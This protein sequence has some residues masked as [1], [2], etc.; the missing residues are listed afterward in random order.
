MTTASRI[1][2]AVVLVAVVAAL[3]SAGGAQG[4]RPDVDWT[5]GIVDGRAYVSWAMYWGDEEWGVAYIV[6]SQDRDGHTY[7]YD[8][9][10]FWPPVDVGDWAGSRVLPPGT[11]DVEIQVRAGNCGSCAQFFQTRTITA[12]PLPPDVP[13]P[14]DDG[15]GD[16]PPLDSDG[17]GVPDRTDTCI[18]VPNPDQADTDADGLG[19]PCDQSPLPPIRVERYSRAPTPPR[20]GTAFSMGLYI[21]RADTG[22]RIVSASV[23]CRATLA[24]KELRVRV[25]RFKQGV[26]TC[27]WWLPRAA[28]G[29][30]FRAEIAV[31]ANNQVVQRTYSA[32]TRPP[33]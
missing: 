22:E 25:A 18:W 30:R 32:K 10:D 21:V 2:I 20:A 15:A 26:G 23:S 4:A 9:I 17:D 5:A 13:P 11:Y 8:T 19:D 14:S 1:R 7:A 3:A 29:K 33:S 28:R 31:E 27:A 24:G 6:V 16:T 12:P